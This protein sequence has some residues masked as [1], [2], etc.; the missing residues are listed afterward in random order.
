MKTYAPPLSHW[1]TLVGAVVVL[2][3]GCGEIDDTTTADSSASS[4]TTVDAT[5]L[6]T[7]APSTTVATETTSTRPP[8]ALDRCLRRAEFGDPVDSP[9]VLPYPLGEGYTIIQSYCNDDGSHEGQ[10]AYDFAMPLGSAVVA[11][12]GGVVV[13]VKEDVADDEHSRFLNYVLIRHRDGT[14]G[15]YAHLQHLGAL[16]D[17]G[18]EVAQGDEIGLSGATGRTGGPVLH[19]GVYSSWP[20]VEGRDEPIVFSNADGP[21]DSRGGLREGSFY[22]ATRTD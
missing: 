14:I 6:A 5:P 12:R 2:L 20:P 19:F 1:V 7:A 9:Y 22:A 16:V 18:A 13:E 17:V 15:F 4:T 21:L 3:A 8:P 11:A 10:L